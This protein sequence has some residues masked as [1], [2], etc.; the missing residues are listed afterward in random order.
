MNIS[1]KFPQPC[2]RQ[3][4]SKINKPDWF[5]RDAIF[6]NHCRNEND[7][8]RSFAKK[9]AGHD[10]KTDGNFSFESDKENWSVKTE[11]KKLRNK[12][13]I[14]PPLTIDEGLT[15]AISGIFA[16]FTKLKANTLSFFAL[17]RI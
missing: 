10:D 15:K 6:I 13:I 1:L 12:L 7:F 9:K 11:K 16:N 2:G 3:I 14:F 5:R 17:I 4:S 8:A